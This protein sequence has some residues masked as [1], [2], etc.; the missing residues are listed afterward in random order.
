MYLTLLL[1][2]CLMLFCLIITGKSSIE[3]YTARFS[4]NEPVVNQAEYE[5][6]IRFFASY[7]GAYL[8]DL[9]LHLRAK[10]FN[11]YSKGAYASPPNW[12][13]VTLNDQLLQFDVLD[14][15]DHSSEL[16]RQQAITF[17]DS[18]KEQIQQKYSISQLQ[19]WSP[20]WNLNYTRNDKGMI[21]VFYTENGKN[22]VYYL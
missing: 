17:L 8:G 15:M 18:V 9:Y 11:P 2:F 5:K 10:Q 21:T 16:S 4:L 6:D 13:P 7:I 12:I 22:F 3:N 19:Q 14:P 20:L 1:F